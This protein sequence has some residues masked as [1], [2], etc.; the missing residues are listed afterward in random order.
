MARTLFLLPVL[1][2]IALLVVAAGRLP[3]DVC[4]LQGQSSLAVLTEGQLPS[5][6][7]LQRAFSTRQCAAR[8]GRPAR[9]Q[10]E[11]GLVHLALIDQAG[12]GSVAAEAHANLGASALR[13]ALARA[14]LDPLAWTALAYM[15]AV[16]GHDDAARAALAAAD[17]VAPYLPD[18]QDLRERTETL[19]NEA[20]LSPAI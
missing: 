1:G 5:P 19:L 18:I 14:P 3:A 16:L 6:Q 2:L 12:L 9:A 15:E 10:A 11:R 20:A 7:G 13:T 17:Q 4:L 8:F